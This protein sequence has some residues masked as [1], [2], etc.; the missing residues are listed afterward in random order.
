MH[1]ILLFVFLSL[2]LLGVDLIFSYLSYAMFLF[3][4]LGHPW[5]GV[6]VLI[7]LHMDPVAFLFFSENGESAFFFR[8]LNPYAS[9]QPHLDMMQAWA[10]LR[11]AF[12]FKN[13]NAFAPK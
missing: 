4:L 10:F 5:Q 2:F 3:L 13:A 9:L 7:F 1:K 12:A 6:R 8:V 11:D